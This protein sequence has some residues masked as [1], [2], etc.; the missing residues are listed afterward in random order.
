MPD[1]GKWTQDSDPIQGFLDPLILQ[2]L[3]RPKTKKEK[4]IKFNPPH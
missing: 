2:Y 3:W 1:L 4:E